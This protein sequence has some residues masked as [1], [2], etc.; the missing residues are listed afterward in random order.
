MRKHAIA[1]G[2]AWYRDGWKLLSGQPVV[3]TLIAL[4]E[5]L[6]NLALAPL[7]DWGDFLSIW[8]AAPLLAGLMFAARE[9]LDGRAARVE[10]AFAGFADR[11]LALLAIGLC[12]TLIAE[13]LRLGVPALLESGVHVLASAGIILA[14]LFGA[15]AAITVL[16]MLAVPRIQLDRIALRPA[17]RDGLAAAA[18]NFGPLFVMLALSVATLAA[19]MLPAVVS[20]VG[21][22]LAMPLYALASAATACSAVI[23]YSS[24]FPG[25]TRHGVQ[26]QFTGRQD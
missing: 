5:S 9:R 16:L 11:I 18:T 19:S 8:L 25:G 24:I 13:G 14:M 4:L 22:L 10:H 12:C 20:D 6:V 17:M 23:A 2:F 7:E 15:T 21:W 26:G 1:A 3:L